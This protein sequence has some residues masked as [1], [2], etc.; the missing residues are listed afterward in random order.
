LKEALVTTPL[1]VL[2]D[3]HRS[4]AAVLDA[5][6]YLVQMKRKDGAEISP[7]VFSAMLYYLDV[8]AERVHHPK[9]EAHLFAHLREHGPTAAAVLDELERE[10]AVG[11]QAMRDL[12]QAFLRYAEGGDAEFTTFATK[13]DRFVDIYFEHMRKEEE[14]VMPY[15]RSVLTAQDW[16]EIEEGF[17]A[18]ADPLVSSGVD[19]RSLFSRIVNIVPAPLGLGSRVN[20][21]SL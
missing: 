19:Y 2:Y 3:E 13:V 20:E 16:K 5:M 17:A 6:K 15:A 12:E 10:H 7:R 18:D 8:F 1:Q 11:E 21:R 4:I 9:E 14:V